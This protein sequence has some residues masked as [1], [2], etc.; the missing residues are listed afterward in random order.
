MKPTKLILSI[1]VIFILLIPTLY[2]QNNESIS[3][4]ELLNMPLEDMM[5]VKISTAG[6]KSEKIADIPASVVLITRKEIEKYGYMT[7]EEI[8]E[9][10]LGMY[11]IDDLGAYRKTYGVR[12][13][14]TGTPRN[15]I[16]LVNGVS[17]AEGVFDFNV[18]ANFYIPVEAIDRI[19]VVRGPMS[20]MYGQGA[21]FGAI[22]IITNDSYDETNLAA[23]SY[24]NMSRKAAAKIAGTRGDFRYS[25][26]AGYTHSDGSDHALSDMVSD[27]STL[28]PWKIDS[29]ND[30]TEDRLEREATNIIFSGE[31]KSVN[32]D[33]ILNHSPDETIILRP[34]LSEGSVYERDSAKVSLGFKKRVTE[35][36]KIDLRAIYH[37][38]DFTLDWDLG[39]VSFTGSDPGT[40][41]GAADMLELE[42]N[43]F[44]DV[45]ENLDL[46]TGLYYKQYMDPEFS[47][48]INIINLF[49]DDT[50]TDD[51]QLWAAFAQANLH[52]WEKLRFVGGIRVEQMFDYTMIHNTETA[53]TSREY[54]EDDLE[55]TT[56]LAALYSFSDRQ[57]LKLMYGKA[58]ARPS[59][60]PEQGPVGSRLSQSGV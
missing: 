44:I 49:Y 10:V 34:A 48:D 52:P 24:G 33:I 7:L 60:F 1:A 57:V 31:F 40:T 14:Y 22:N 8:L 53:V 20:V 54:D 3:S 13:F 39:L 11:V 56:N 51:I 50:T 5:N 17:Q 9:N 4:N 43:T 28:S 6:K 47:A 18:M 27:M 30:D 32:A 19:E 37:Y 45:N 23:V 29:T 55:F 35:D 41:S 21:F 46:T 2:A 26:S 36:V 15:I 25:L 59:F 16:F 12:G 38:H 58:F 42:L